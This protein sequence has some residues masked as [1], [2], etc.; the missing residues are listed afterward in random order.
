MGIAAALAALDGA[1]QAVV[2]VRSQGV[3]FIPLP[4]RA[5]ITPNSRGRLFDLT[6]TGSGDPGLAGFRTRRQH[7]IDLTVLYPVGFGGLGEESVTIAEDVAKLTVALGESNVGAMAGVGVVYPP[8]EH[9]IEPI[10]PED[11]DSP[12]GLVVT[13]PFVVETQEA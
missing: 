13:L 6:V 12:V 2:P 1:I 7:L 11:R 8:A 10:T 9:T 3:P 4:D 5:R